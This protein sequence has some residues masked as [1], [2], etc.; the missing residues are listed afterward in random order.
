VAQV[1]DDRYIYETQEEHDSRIKFENRRFHQNKKR[2]R[3]KPRNVSIR[4]E[5]SIR[6][7][8][9]CEICSFA[10][11]NI[12]VAHHILPV[13]YGGNGH[14]FNLA[15]ICP[16]CHALVHN[17]DH[18]PDRFT[19]EKKY[20]AWMRGLSK[21]GLNEKQASRLLLIASKRARIT[22]EGSVIPYKEPDPLIP[23]IVDENGKPLDDRHDPAKIN[24]ALRY[25]EEVFGM[26]SDEV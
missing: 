17:Y 21:A 10:F 1:V 3:N 24:A 26:D 19:V 23:I 20:P 15:L 14:P 18:Y 8:G 16:N 9:K 25:I 6:S 22:K 12:L 11:S 13:S 7:D 2:S 5:L 4:R